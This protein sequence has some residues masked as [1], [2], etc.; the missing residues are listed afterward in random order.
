MSIGVAENL[1]TDKEKRRN[2]SALKSCTDVQIVT[3]ACVIISNVH[4]NYSQ[5]G[6][7]FVPNISHK[8]YKDL[9]LVGH[10]IARPYIYT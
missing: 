2:F 3:V 7:I 4:L 10:T 5:N 6:F 1:H 9:L 8:A